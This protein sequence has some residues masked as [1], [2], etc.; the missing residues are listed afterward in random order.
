MSH[1]PQAILKQY[2]RLSQVSHCRG[3]KSRLYKNTKSSQSNIQVLFLLNHPLLPTFSFNTEQ[4]EFPSVI[5]AQAVITAA[6]STIL[7][8]KLI[9]RIALYVKTGRQRS[10]CWHSTVK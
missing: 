7:P 5:I 2:L 1:I 6:T 8:K 10:N 3:M 4:S 9:I